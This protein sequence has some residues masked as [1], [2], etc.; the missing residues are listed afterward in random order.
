MQAGPA[1]NG[2]CV[3]SGSDYTLSVPVIPVTPSVRV[4][5]QSR[6]ASANWSASVYFE[7]CCGGSVVYS[8]SGGPGQCVAVNPLISSLY[9]SVDCTGSNNA[10]T[11]GG[12]GDGGG[13]QS[14]PASRFAACT[15]TMRFQLRLDVPV[16][17]SPGLYGQQVQR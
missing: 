12:T 6:C 3:T 14:C 8:T 10:G 5:C 4:T 15:H 17:L 2:N 1:T 16:P 7:S 13:P 11:R 9:M